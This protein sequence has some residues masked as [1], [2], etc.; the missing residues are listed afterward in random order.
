M[1]L[2]PVRFRDAETPLFFQLQHSGDDTDGDNEARVLQSRVAR[3]ERAL[4]ALPPARRDYCPVRLALEYEELYGEPAPPGASVFWLMAR[5]L[6]PP[7][8]EALVPD[9]FQQEKQEEEVPLR[10]NV[11]GE[12]PFVTDTSFLGPGRKLEP[13]RHYGTARLMNDDGRQLQ[14][15][16]ACCGELVGGPRDYGGCWI[17]LFDA[18]AEPGLI[19]P[20]QLWYDGNHD[21]DANGNRIWDRLA[22]NTNDPT[23]R[24]TI[25]FSGQVGTAFQDEALY[26][27]YNERIQELLRQLAPTFHEC[28]V[29]YAEALDRISVS[30][31]RSYAALES[32]NE[33]PYRWLVQRGGD[34]V[35]EAVKEL[36]STV[37]LFNAPQNPC[38][39]DED[40]RTPEDW[41][42]HVDH[43]MFRALVGYGAFA[44]ER[45]NFVLL[46]GE[47]GSKTRFVLPTRS[48]DADAYADFC[49]RARAHAAA[50]RVSAE[51]TALAERLS[52]KVL[53]PLASRRTDLSSLMEAAGIVVSNLRDLT[54]ALY[55]SELAPLSPYADPL[56]QALAALASTQQAAVQAINRGFRNDVA[57]GAAR[58]AVDAAQAALDRA[59]NL[60]NAIYDSTDIKPENARHLAE[61]VRVTDDAYGALDASNIHNAE[62][63]D[64]L[65]DARAYG[66]PTDALNRV[67]DTWR[68]VTAVANMLAELESSGNPYFRNQWNVAKAR[69]QSWAESADPEGALAAAIELQRAAN[70]QAI[71]QAPTP[72][73]PTTASRSTLLKDVADIFNSTA[74]L[75][76]ATVARAIAVFT[77]RVYAT[78]GIELEPVW[79]DY[80]GN[81][82]SDL[83]R[84]EPVVTKT[85][86]AQLAQ[87]LVMLANNPT[88][89]PIVLAELEE[90]WEKKHAAAAAAAAVAAAKPPTEPKNVPRR[91]RIASARAAITMS[92]FTFEAN[93]CP[94]DSAFT[95]LFK[96]PQSW[97]SRQVL[98]ATVLQPPARCSDAETVRFH[99]AVVDDVLFLQGTSQHE[100]HVT[101][102][103]E[104]WRACFGLPASNVA[105]PR[106]LFE[107]LLMLYRLRDHVRTLYIRNCEDDGTPL[108]V[109]D[110]NDT[111][112]EQLD[113]AGIPLQA[114]E[115]TGMPEMILYSSQTAESRAAAE[116]ARIAFVPVKYYGTRRIRGVDM[117][118]APVVH[119]EISGMGLVDESVQ[120]QLRACLSN[121]GGNHWV[122]YVHDPVTGFWHSFDALA[123]ANGT[124]VGQPNV[125][126]EAVARGLAGVEQPCAWIYV[127]MATDDDL[128]E[129]V[130]PPQ[131]NEE[132]DDDGAIVLGSLVEADVDFG[133]LIR[134]FAF[135]DADDDAA[136]QGGFNIA[137]GELTIP[138]RLRDDAERRANYLSAAQQFGRLLD[139]ARRDEDPQIMA[140]IADDIQH[141]LAAARLAA[142]T[143]VPETARR[144]QRRK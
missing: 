15:R 80:V 52:S 143:P 22:L 21:V 122:S 38:D 112:P 85:D 139:A 92:N 135:G 89:P 26:R 69:V 133:D 88:A 76:T 2:P 141:N 106:E 140:T 118:K 94:F 137:T 117:T 6:T 42:R 19:I 91:D 45:R 86:L 107:N 116:G 83:Q 23:V 29:A 35:L 103:R 96:V 56:R 77:D 37:A 79:Q 98:S 39:N 73:E 124:I 74:K 120:Y 105:D 110:I 82:L 81:L 144:Q 31:D 101:R 1:A 36:V 115:P 71:L 40:P 34:G 53:M 104:P 12:A 28:Y 72:Q 27:R 78:T 9:F 3:V 57:L 128:G 84:Y 47:G 13:T 123:H 138:L 18:A 126:P 90:T 58:A 67:Y 25:L 136:Q 20:Y 95:A 100:R 99:E 48:D 127:K 41:Q 132:E 49:R 16:W 113:D 30:D 102:T 66:V 63:D 7:E 33:T 55:A 60:Q 125:V 43:V 68:R 51:A 108:D 8:I 32:N 5:M 129:G 130:A 4:K 54:K 109:W 119:R 44:P 17:A 75:S 14:E 24:D 121:R 131:P 65:R 111:R 10:R 11:P 97:L 59:T 61:A 142:P 46:R 70:A 50:G 134:N 114:L 87:E 64:A 62:A 93:S